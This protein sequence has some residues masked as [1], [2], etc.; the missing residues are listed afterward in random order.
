MMG[1]ISTVLANSSAKLEEVRGHRHQDD[2]AESYQ[3]EH[4]EQEG[5]KMP[6]LGR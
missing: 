5:I 1:N 2:S 3:R 6:G 4:K